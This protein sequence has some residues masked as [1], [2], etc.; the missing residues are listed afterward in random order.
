MSW[1][2]N[3]IY[4]HHIAEYPQAISLLAQWFQNEW[5]LINE[6]ATIDSRQEDLKSRISQK[7]LPLTMLAIDHQEILGTYS[8]D[9]ADLPIRPLWSPWLASVFVNPLHRKK[10]IGT[11]LVQ[12]GL[13]HSQFLGIKTLYLFTTN[14]ANWYA[15][16]GFQVIE[17]LI[18]C[19]ERI[20]VMRHKME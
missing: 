2:V 17:K 10:G 16:M 18:Y 12:K 15:S 20:T 14:R 9:L 7:S 19:N 1:Q 5:S 3:K 8:L 6:T 4:W 11:L 13:E